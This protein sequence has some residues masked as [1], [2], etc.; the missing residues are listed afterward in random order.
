MKK[1]NL[2]CMTCQKKIKKR[3]MKFRKQGTHEGSMMCLQC[4]NRC[5]MNGY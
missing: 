4:E 1:V 2:F 5:V 3:D